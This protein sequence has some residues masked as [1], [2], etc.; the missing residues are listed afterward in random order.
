VIAIL[1]GLFMLG[2]MVGILLGSGKASREWYEWGILFFVGMML[3]KLS[4]PVVHEF[5]TFL[6]DRDAH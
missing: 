2:L 5:R 4:A 3:W 6:K 1:F